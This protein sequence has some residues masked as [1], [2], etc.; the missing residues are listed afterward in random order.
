MFACATL[1]SLSAGNAQ[2]AQFQVSPV[3]LDLS[4][5]ASSGLLNVRNQ[6]TEPIRFQVTGF[7]WQ[8]SQGGEVQLQPTKDLAFFPSMLTVPAGGS[9]KVRVG[10]LTPQG[11]AESTYRVIV[12]ELPSLKPANAH[13]PNAVRVLTRM[14]IPV[15][16]AALTPASSPAIDGLS[17]SGG[18]LTFAVKN[19]G[20]THFMNQRIQILATDSAGQVTHDTAAAGWYVLGAGS[21]RYNLVLPAAACSGLSKITVKLETSRGPTSATIPASASQCTP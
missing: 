4:A 18:R 11:T 19:R 1:L 8:Q 5:Q 21:R 16:F 10:T 14:S 7:A 20:N 3:R 17:M 13:A 12:E 6:S 9:R 15:F 2:A